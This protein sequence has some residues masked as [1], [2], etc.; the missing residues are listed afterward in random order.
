MKTSRD[1]EKT[2]PDVADAIDSF[3]S[4]EI[5]CRRLAV[6]GA[7]P[8]EVADI[9]TASERMI[10]MLGKVSL[11]QDCKIGRRS[12]G[13]GFGLCFDELSCVGVC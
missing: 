2:K 13:F 8:V 6:E 12:F 7:F 9:T 11:R 1:T 4:V 3:N 10:P 5:S